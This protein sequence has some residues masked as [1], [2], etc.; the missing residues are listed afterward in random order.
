VA[1]GE[2]SDHWSGVGGHVKS[3]KNGNLLA[4][5]DA[6]YWRHKAGLFSRTLLTQVSVEDRAVLDVGC[7]PGG[8]LRY[9]SKRNPKRLIG[10]DISPVMLGLAAKSAPTAELIEVDGEHLPFGDDELDVV[11]TVTVVQHNPPDR[12]KN[13]LSEICRV[14][15]EEVFL[16]EDIMWSPAL[17]TGLGAYE[18]Y[19]ARPVESY[20]KICEQYGFELAEQESLA[21]YVSC[22]THFFLRRLDRRNRTEGSPHSQGLL[23]IEAALLPLTRRLDKLAPHWPQVFPRKYAPPENT[24]MHFVRRNP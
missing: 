9:F 5:D 21:T 2:D 14:A 4:G 1:K 12:A 23:A 7:G 19:W 15:K 11:T 13:L 3:R 8:T 24:M 22:R 20:Q 6:P 16:F 17:E 10:C 18:N